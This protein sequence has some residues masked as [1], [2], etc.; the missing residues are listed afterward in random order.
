MTPSPAA[1]LAT[2]K[3]AGRS[4]ILTYHSIDTS[5]SVISVP[6]SVFR[7][8]MEFLAASGIPVAPLDQVFHQPGS[9]AITFDDGFANLAEH[10][11]PL[12][13]RY[14]L[15]ATVFVV[16]E[17][18]GRHND[19]PSQPLGAV[20]ILPLLNWEDL[21]KLP[22]GIDIG[23]HTATHP[24]LSRLPAQDCEREMNSCRQQI[25]QRLGKAV[26][27]F[28]YPYGASSP[29]VRKLAARNFDLAVGTS[30]RFLPAQPDRMD[31]PRIDAYYLRESF[32]LER[33]FGSSGRIYIAMRGLLR[34]IRRL[35]SG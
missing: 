7:S 21:Q 13:E 35:A 2:D 5:G 16:S 32:P 25:E 10:A 19:W 8:Q 14:G 31:L 1:D 17:Y 22:A 26:P 4:A 12:L 28:A 27:C 9:V 23:A 29:E 24:D 3:I 33:L 20:P 30:L 18:C 11:F 6:P 34:D 15:P